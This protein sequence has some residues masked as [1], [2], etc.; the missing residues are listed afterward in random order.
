MTVGIKTAEKSGMFEEPEKCNSKGP[1]TGR[2]EKLF[3]GG[4]KPDT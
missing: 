3:S 1:K 4:V 2:R